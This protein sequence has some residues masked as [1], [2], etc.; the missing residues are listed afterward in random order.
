[1]QCSWLGKELQSGVKA[2]HSR[3]FMLELVYD[4]TLADMRCEEGC[5]HRWTAAAM[6]GRAA[7]RWKPLQQ[8][9]LAPQV[10]SWSARCQ[11]CS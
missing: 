8:R 7:S 5:L 1:M 6:H 3:D 11:T 2:W 10:A 4:V 9:P